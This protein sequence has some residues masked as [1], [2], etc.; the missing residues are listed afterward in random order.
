MKIK[1]LSYV[2]AIGG[3]TAAC[4]GG[5][6]KAEPTVEPVESQLI[7]GIDKQN[8]DTSHQACND[9]W[10][11]ACGGWI[12][13]NPI[14]Q[15]EGRWGTFSILAENN[16][17]KV[18]SILEEISQLEKFDNKRQE[19]I[20]KFYKSAMDTN[21][22]NAQ[23]ILP[24]KQQIEDI[25][26]IKNSNDLILSFAQ[27]SKLGIK[28]PLN[29]SVSADDRNSSAYILKLYQSGLGLPDRS[30]YL[31]DN[32]KYADIRSMYKKY[33]TDIMLKMGYDQ[34]LSDKASDQII[35]L[36]KNM[37]RFSMERVVMREPD[38][39]YHK[40]NTT[41]LVDQN[42]NL[43]FDKYFNTLGIEPTELIVAQPYFIKGINQL[44]K[45]TPINIWK[46]YLKFHLINSMASYLDSEIEAL[47]FNFYARD[48]R[49]VEKMKPRWKNVV[50]VANSKIGDLV[51]QEFTARYFPE[52]SKAKVATMVEN[53]RASFKDRINNL[54]WMG[55][56]TKKEALKKLAAFN[57]KI[58]YPEEWKDFS[59]VELN[60]DSYAANILELNLNGTTKN[61]DKL[62]KPV[63]KK[64][65][66]M[67]VQIVNAYYSPEFNEIVFPAGILQPPFFNPEAEDA[68]NYGGIGAVIGHEFTHGFDDQ[69][70]KYDAEGN[71]RE[72]WTE[73]D[74]KRF[75]EKTN[76]LVEQYNSYEALPNEFVNGKLTLGENIADLGGLTLA[77]Y[78]YQKSLNGEASPVI[79][80]TSGEQRFFLG[81]GQVWA[82]SYKDAMLSQ[83]LKV[84][85]HS[86]AMFR[87]RGP[88]KN[89]VEFEQAFDC[90]TNEAKA[91]IW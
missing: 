86:P 63:D 84:D 34:S 64:E 5:E 59:N 79:D 31:E 26:N 87:V 13:N 7:S 69:G 67:P 52:E 48:L 89:M 66:F 18:K 35:A 2:L 42:P 50:S 14:P 10:H 8:L 29:A 23:G 15:T 72:W 73:D 36:E 88:V 39:V 71:L 43:E 75:N 44:V 56:A 76:L 60:G 65:W 33:I 62:G 17:Q 12:K 21:A 54:D 27:L 83:M 74:R 1:T 6:K 55:E 3:F 85:P 57:F 70:S 41:D 24:L 4:S 30:Y 25:D 19:Q 58:G 9:F 37:A 11:Y 45:S 78:A 38:S 77:Y 80:G 47:N 68:V 51:G 53:L 46:D 61:L 40:M 82:S 91:L 81:W 22:I 90:E 16:N 49:G 20:S 28:T 32:E